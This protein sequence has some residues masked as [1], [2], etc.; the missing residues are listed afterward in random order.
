MMAELFA[1]KTG[2]CK[3][4]G[5]SMHIC[6]LSLGIIGSNGIVGAGLPIAVGAG[7]AAQKK[8]KK[9]VCVCFFG[10][11]AANRGTFNESINLASAWK[12]PV[13]YVCENNLYGISGCVRDTMNI[14]NISDRSKSYGIPGVTVDGNDIL[15][16]YD[17]SKKAIDYARK[18]NG[19]YLLEY[20]TWR[21]R[22]HWEGDLDLYRDKEEKKEWLSKDPIERF[23]DLII[24]DGYATKDKLD[25]I[26]KEIISELENAVEFAKES[27]VPDPKD[28]YTDVYV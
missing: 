7:F 20:K 12:L 21:H 16:V 14:S 18:G 26:N 24:K 10:D 2:Y 4:K 3:G 1:K 11:G 6:D 5:G 17:S 23:K 9:G 27:P 13:V 8:A 28:L 25:N 22:G 15:A 19:P